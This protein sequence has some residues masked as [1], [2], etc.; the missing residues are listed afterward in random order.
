M[1]KQ[2]YITIHHALH[3]DA[4]VVTIGG[5]DYP[6]QKAGNG[7]RYID[8]S[9]IR[10]MQQNKYKDSKWAKQ[11]RAGK[12]ISWVMTEPTWIRIDEE[13]INPPKTTAN[14]GGQ[15]QS[16]HPTSPGNA[17]AKKDNRR[18]GRNFWRG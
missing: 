11:A 2:V 12:K 1:V 4:A 14:N 13:T 15:T 6:I 5:I 8:Y 17:I 18:T 3:S 10:V 16:T 9:G 7:C